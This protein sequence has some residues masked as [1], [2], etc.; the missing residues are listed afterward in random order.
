MIYSTAKE[1]LSAADGAY[2]A[3]ERERVVASETLTRLLDCLEQAVVLTDSC[4]AIITT[5][6]AFC[7]MFETWPSRHLHRHLG[8]IISHSVFTNLL[9]EIRATEHLRDTRNYTLMLPPCSGCSCHRSFLLHAAVLPSG[10]R[11]FVF[12]DTT[13]QKDMERRFAEM[14]AALYNEMHK[15]C[16]YFQE[17]GGILDGENAKD[18]SACLEFRD[19]TRRMHRVLG[20]LRRYCELQEP[21]QLRRQNVDMAALVQA[22]CQ[23]VA[24]DCLGRDI[25]LYV[26]EAGET[27]HVQGDPD[28]LEELV[29]QVLHN[30]QKFAPLEC[31][32]HTQC[33]R[34]DGYLVLTFTDNGRGMLPGYEQLATELFFQEPA[35]QQSYGGLG[36]G[37]PLARRIATLHGGGLKLKSE[38]GHGVTVW[39]WLG[40]ENGG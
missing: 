26:E 3:M 18:P 11:L 17:F 5:N 38:P 24:G 6:Q 20:M 37:L 29:Y 16:L 31:R 25:Q 2:T 22:V 39:V 34:Q 9:E 23:R 32:I 8:S 1:A 13:R 14:C 21:M 28:L 36:L 4:L 15:F 35:V 30:A 40:L 7:R 19:K 27:P 10:N 33:L 12:S